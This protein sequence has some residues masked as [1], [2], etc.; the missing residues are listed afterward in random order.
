[1]V[2]YYK[3]KSGGFK[4]KVGAKR[5]TGGR[6]Y[7]GAMKGLSLVKLAGQTAKIMRD[8]NV[9]KKYVNIN[10]ALQQAVHANLAAAYAITPP[11]L[12]GT[13]G[14]ERNGNSVKVT[15][16]RFDIQLQ[17]QDIAEPNNM[18]YK[19]YLV[20][21]KGCRVT[22]TGADV[23]A[24]TLDVNPFTGNYDYHALADRD[25]RKE[26][27]VMKT[28]YGKITADTDTQAQDDLSH[29]T[30]NMRLNDRLIYDTDASSNPQNINYWL[31]V[32]CDK[33]AV[34]ALNGILFQWSAR[35]TFVDN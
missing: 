28:S 34:S 21:R 3:R 25:N 6:L 30:I 14:D 18:R 12:Q 10:P 15:G 8:L 1:M 13:G 5:S 22:A 26:F 17:A 20:K 7:S 11:I 23:I 31:I 35:W 2:K 29:R 33:G 27:S 24:A 9:E 16:L 4:R 19:F 32:T